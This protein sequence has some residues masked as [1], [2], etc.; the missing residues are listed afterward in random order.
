[1]KIKEIMCGADRMRTEEYKMSCC[2]NTQS[3]REESSDKRKGRANLTPI[4]VK[5]V[6]VTK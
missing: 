4:S 1:M 5:P 6:Y 2:V 3:N